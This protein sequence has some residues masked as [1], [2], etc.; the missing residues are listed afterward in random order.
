MRQENKKIKSVP[1]LVLV[2]VLV[3]SFI[4]SGFFRVPNVE[5]SDSWLSDYDYRRRVNISQ[6]SGAGVDYPFN[7]TLYRNRTE[8][9]TAYFNDKGTSQPINWIDYPSAY[10]YNNVTYFVYQYGGSLDNYIKTYN[11]TSGEWSDGVKVHDGLSSDDHGAPA[12]LVDGSGVI[13]VF[14]G[15]HNGRFKYANTSSPEDITT[16][17]SST[18]IGDTASTY[19]HPFEADNGSIYCFSRINGAPRDFGYIRSDDG[20][21]SWESDVT[22]VDDDTASLGY[23]QIAYDSTNERVHIGLVELTEPDTGDR[24]DLFHLYLDLSSGDLYNMSGNNLGSSVNLTT[25]DNSCMVYDTSSGGDESNI[26]SIHLDPSGYPHLINPIKNGS[27]D[28]CHYHHN[29]DGSSWQSSEITYAGHQFDHRDFIIHGSSN[30]TAYLSVSPDTSRGGDIEKWGWDGSSWTKSETLMSE[31]SYPL[32][33]P[34][35]PANHT[36]I[37]CIWTETNA[38]SYGY[39]GL[40]S[41]AYDGDGFVLEAL[42]DSEVDLETKVNPGFTDINITASDGVTPLSMW[43]YNKSSENNINL[44]FKVTDNITAS[45]TYIY[46]YYGNNT[47]VSNTFNGSAVFTDFDD[48]EDTDWSEWTEAGANSGGQSRD[49]TYVHEGDYCLKFPSSDSSCYLEKTGLSYTSHAVGVFFYTHG[50]ST[51]QFLQCKD[52]SGTEN[53]IAEQDEY[54]SDHY[55]VTESGSNSESSQ[56]QSS[57]WHHAELRVDGGYTHVLDDSQEGN[58]ATEDDIDYIAIADFHGGQTDAQYMDSFYIRK[59]VSGESEPVIGDEE[60]SSGSEPSS[61][62]SPIA[63]SFSFDSL[64]DGYKIMAGS[65][66]DYHANLWVSD[67]DGTAD[68]DYAKWAFQDESGQWYNVTVDID[69]HEWI[70]AT[71]CP[72]TVSAEERDSVN[73]TQMLIETV[74]NLWE[75]VPE[76][77]GVSVYAWAN[78]TAGDTSGWTLMDIDAFDIVPYDTDDDDDDDD[79]DP[80]P[81]PDPGPDPDPEPDPDSDICNRTW[82]ELRSIHELV[83]ICDSNGVAYPSGATKQDLIRLIL[84]EICDMCELADCELSDQELLELLRELQAMEWADL[85]EYGRDM[86]AGTT[87]WDSRETA[88]IKIFIEGYGCPVPDE[89][90]DD[91][92]EDSD[93]DGLPDDI[94]PD[95][96][97]DGIPDEDDPDDDGDG[98]PDDEEGFDPDD[99][100]GDGEPNDVDPE[101]Y[102]PDEDSSDSNIP[103]FIEPYVPGPVKPWIQNYGDEIIIFSALAI[104]LLAAL[105]EDEKKKNRKTR[106]RQDFLGLDHTRKEYDKFVE[107]LKKDVWEED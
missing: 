105:D 83:R 34:M 46:L 106:A 95:D 107:K 66:R 30:I 74:I 61:N 88:I 56:G 19:P 69:D 70:R 28:W 103:D 13:H 63:D 92:E 39:S 37:E 1:S 85:I 55:L 33:N 98:I 22:L 60:E 62:N 58:S 97:N 87:K 80:E 36:Y 102:N 29:W 16:F 23:A 54:S 44:W 3:V 90:Y 4:P 38:G 79:D 77:P 75:E 21:A 7:I 40:K 17:H 99:Y 82:L 47:S 101:P 26:P 32:N 20:G 57:G 10:F 73:S 96:D 84:C 86:G 6:C 78:D 52:D 48:F 11:H 9:D 72:M 104:F 45:D 64:T 31:G 94:D 93:D 100:D 50:S 59:Y 8:L 14:G 25:L 24:Q 41:Y 12:I 91:P 76:T 65:S 18:S 68:L 71:E 89:F 49:S 35:V 43:K 53:N 51:S 27:G 2:A 81:G 67:A 42:T 5:A 15:A